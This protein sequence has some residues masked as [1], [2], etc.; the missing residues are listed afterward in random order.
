MLSNSVY[1]SIFNKPRKLLH[2]FASLFFLLE[3]SVRFLP[4]L[5]S[6]YIFLKLLLVFNLNFVAKPRLSLFIRFNFELCLCME[7]PK[8]VLGSL[9]EL[10]L[11]AYMFKFSVLVSVSFLVLF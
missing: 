4:S 5:I 9:E 2:T 1:S 7:K 3:D 11:I 6:I 10:N 8:L